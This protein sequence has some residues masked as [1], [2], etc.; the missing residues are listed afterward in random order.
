M[1]LPETRLALKVGLAT[2]LA[3]LVALCLQLQDAYWVGISAFLIC[4]EQVGNSLDKM[5]QRILC[6]LLGAVCGLIVVHFLIE[7]P[8]GLVLVAFLFITI[9][10]Y[11]GFKNDNW[12]IW[13]F[14]LITFFMVVTTVFTG[15]KAHAVLDVALYRSWDIIV[16]SVIGFLVNLLVFPVRAGAVLDAAL[17]L[18]LDEFEAYYD[19]VMQSFFSS[20]TEAGLLTLRDRLV[21]KSARL[22][23]LRRAAEKEAVF[24]E[25]ERRRVLVHF[26]RVQIAVTQWLAMVQHFDGANLRYL[27]CYQREFAEVQACFK[28][29]L[30]NPLQ[31]HADL[32]KTLQQLH[33]RYDQ[34][35]HEGLNFQYSLEA[36]TVFHECV[37][38]HQ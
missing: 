37:A 4:A 14:T 26:E 15:A 34:R 6:T 12:Y 31:A 16:G 1:M 35:R 13:I 2:A 3:T 18:F 36:V 38:L 32:K 9:L 5:I 8:I 10:T 23:A 11:Q 27:Q 7:D 28:R 20:K 33:L 25:G 30:R 17:P 24:F 29:F 21:A 19:A 22:S